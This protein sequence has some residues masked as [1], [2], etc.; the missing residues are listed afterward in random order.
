MLSHVLIGSVRQGR[1]ARDEL[2]ELRGVAE[3]SDTAGSFLTP[4]EALV[5]AEAIAKLPGVLPHRKN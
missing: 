4:A 5:I 1:R 3:Q 2:R